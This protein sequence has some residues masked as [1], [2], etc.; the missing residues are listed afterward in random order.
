[1]ERLVER[2]HCP[3]D[4]AKNRISAQMSM[5]NKLWGAHFIIDNDGDVMSTKDQ[6]FLIIEKLN[7]S[8]LHLFYRVV[9]I[10]L[11]FGALVMFF[12]I[13]QRF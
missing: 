7:K 1:M 3:V 12:R 10:G 4:E 11:F 13:F 9:F 6:T 5:E 2:D 8:H